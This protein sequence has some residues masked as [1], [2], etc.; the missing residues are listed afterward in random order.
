[1]DDTCFLPGQPMTIDFTNTLDFIARHIPLSVLT[2]ILDLS[3]DTTYPYANR[4][5]DDVEKVEHTK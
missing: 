3:Y 2:L 1:M 5:V 4:G